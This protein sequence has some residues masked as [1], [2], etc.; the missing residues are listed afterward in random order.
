MRFLQLFQSSP[1]GNSL[2]QEGSELTFSVNN[3]GVF[4]VL[5]ASYDTEI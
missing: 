5:F 2:N 4:Q 1:A 3:S